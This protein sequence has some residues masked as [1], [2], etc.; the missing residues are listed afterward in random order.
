[1]KIDDIQVLATPVKD[2]RFV[3]CFRGAGF[4]MHLLRMTRSM[5]E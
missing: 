4:G 3:V 1:M 2:Y 5:R